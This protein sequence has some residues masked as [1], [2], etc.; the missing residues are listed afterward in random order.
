MVDGN[1]ITCIYSNKLLKA[2]QYKDKKNGF[3]DIFWILESH[4]YCGNR[5]DISIQI[6]ELFQKVDKDIRN[7]FYPFAKFMVMSK[8]WD[9]YKDFADFVV[10]K[11]DKEGIAIVR[12]YSRGKFTKKE[13]Q[14]NLDPNF[15]KDEVMKYS[16]KLLLKYHDGR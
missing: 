11:G 1:L 6:L 5:E 12:R 8:N 2:Y 4:K 15:S 9:W 14:M 10:D 13:I 16:R 3:S 7:N